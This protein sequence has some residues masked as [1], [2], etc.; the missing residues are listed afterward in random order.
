[1]AT[2]H[3]NVKTPADFQKV[4]RGCFILFNKLEIGNMESIISTNIYAVTI[5]LRLFDVTFQ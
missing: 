4:C 2:S 3:K 1:M 5:K